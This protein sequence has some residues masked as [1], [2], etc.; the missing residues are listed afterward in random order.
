MNIADRLGLC[1]S[2]GPGARHLDDDGTAGGVVH[3]AVV[4]GIAVHCRPDSQ[5]IPVGGEDHGFRF[6]LRIAALH[7]RDHVAGLNLPHL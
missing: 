5:M 3:R 4:N 2:A 6:E 7:L 1:S